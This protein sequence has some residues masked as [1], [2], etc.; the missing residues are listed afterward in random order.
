MQKKL[1][2]SKLLYVI[3]SVVMAFA[4]WCYVTTVEGVTDTET[5]PNIP[6]TF[7]G[8]D[9][10]LEKGLMITSDVPAVTMKFQAT[11]ANLVKLKAD[12]AVSI[13]VDV[14]SITQP[15]TYTMAY[16]VSYSGISRSNF[17][18]VE[19][20]PA[21]ITFVVESYITREVE[22]RGQFKGR[23]AE[24]YM[25]ELENNQPVFEFAPQ[26]LKVSGMEN[27]V[28][29]ISHA[30]VTIKDNEI[31]KTIERGFT[32]E[33]IGWDDKPLDK[34]AL[35]IECH[36]ETIMTTLKVQ[37]YTEIPL[38]VELVDGGGAKQN[39][40][41]EWDYSPKSITV[42]GE[43]ADVKTL[44]SS[45]KITVAKINLA[46]I[47]TGETT[48]VKTIPLAAELTNLDG[49]TEVTIE[50]KISGFVSKTL[51]V[52]EFDIQ[53]VPIGLTATVQTKHLFVEVRG[54]EEELEE[55]TADNLRVVA[56]LANIDLAAGQYTVNA[57]IY[58]DGIGDAG[59]MGTYPL[60]VRLAASDKKQ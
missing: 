12:G 18:V 4:L 27:D 37:M 15:G 59:V 34:G 33:L 40:N 14:A 24:G 48:L 26:T 11:A 60:A 31:S 51:E 20:N 8:E 43:P 17:T 54:T 16:D 50:I 13:S 36:D 41:V 9:M 57:K 10:L 32:Y 30:L 5:I 49:V 3:F 21:N 42:A 2:D 58:F 19:Q 46:E 29:K 39:K 55:A 25:L 44:L 6:V 7:E 23:V 28:N 53:N 22:I 35:A 47:E 56:D 45:G 38:V 1:L 52:T